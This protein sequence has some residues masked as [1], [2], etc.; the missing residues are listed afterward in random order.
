MAK[1]RVKKK[2]SQEKLATKKT[3]TKKKAAVKKKPAAKKR[4]KKQPVA[5]AAA[6]P[7]GKF[8]ELYKMETAAPNYDLTTSDII[9]KLTDWDQKYGIV[10]SDVEHDSFNV[11][12]S[13]L[14]KNVAVLAADVY[15]FCP[16]TIDQGFD[17]FPDMLSEG[18]PLGLK[19][20]FTPEQWEFK[21]ELAEGIDFDQPDYGMQL[22]KKQLL[23]GK[24]VGLWWD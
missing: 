24:N 22:L 16:D 20:M 13:R 23:L 2:S 17:A 19:E 12:F 15:D 14:P 5:K 3:A 7:V 8:A 1:K 10:I 9:A 4:T 11:E 21:Q 18:D 6:K